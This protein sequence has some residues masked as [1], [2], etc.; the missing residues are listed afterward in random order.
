MQRLRFT[1]QSGGTGQAC[2]LQR[3]ANHS[4]LSF[5]PVE[6]Q[7]QHLAEAAPGTEETTVCRTRCEQAPG[8]VEVGV[9]CVVECLMDVRWV[10]GRCQPHIQ[11]GSNSQ[12]RYVYVGV[13]NYL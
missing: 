8:L 5:S 3:E 6:C 7:E 10:S 9:E 1:W 13:Y 12:D 11:S 4:T 2:S